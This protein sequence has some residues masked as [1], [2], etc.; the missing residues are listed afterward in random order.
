MGRIRRLDRGNTAINRPQIFV[1]NAVYYLPALKGQNDVV[2]GV[3]GDWELARITQYASGTSM[4]FYQNGLTETRLSLVPVRAPV[5][6]SALFGDGYTNHQ[7]PL[8]P[9]KVARPEPVKPGVN[10]HAVTLS[11]IRSVP[12]RRVEPLGYC[13]GPGFVNT[14]FSVDKNWRVWGE[15]V[16]IQFR[17]DFFNLFNHANFHGDQINGFGN[18][19]SIPA[20]V[21]CGPANGAGLYQ[22]CST[23]NNVITRQRTT[24]TRASRSG[25]QARQARATVRFEDHLLTVL[26]IARNTTGSACYNQVLPVVFVRANVQFVARC[27]AGLPIFC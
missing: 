21:N 1:A 23:C 17:M 22:P 3:L 10:P 15:R 24:R 11:A 18:G 16:R 25:T 27:L 12:F 5:A 7:R 26:L 2:Q 8:S 13:H 6:S 20:S 19:G 14:D 4:Y 9:G